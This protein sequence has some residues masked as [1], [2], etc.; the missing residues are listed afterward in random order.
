MREDNGA[1]NDQD[2][3]KTGLW[4][5]VG[6]LLGVAGLTRRD[7]TNDV[8]FAADPAAPGNLNTPRALEQSYR[9]DRQ[10]TE[11]PKAD[12]ARKGLIDS[13]KGK[14]KEIAGAVTGNDSLTV[15]GQLEQTQAQQRKEA[16]SLEAV[17]DAEAAWAHA[18]ATNARLEGAEERIAVSAKTAAVKNSAR[19]EQAAQHRAAEQAGQQHAARAKTQAE[20]D[21]QR[22]VER[23]RAEER[24]EVGAATEEIVDAINEHQTS[25]RQATSARAE[26]DRIRRQADRVT[27]QADLP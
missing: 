17:A 18:D 27:K 22:A 3:D 24:E 6:L 8:R 2:G 11:Q 20:H 14:A 26:A 19:T 1:A 7:D 10:M 4:G 9:E 13:V 23:A 21:A 25:V 16:N 5:L 15:E 12:Q